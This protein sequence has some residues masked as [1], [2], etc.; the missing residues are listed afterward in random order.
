MPG[1]E[2]SWGEVA[3]LLELLHPCWPE[4]LGMGVPREGWA[5]GSS[6]SDR[7]SRADLGHLAGSF[8]TNL[9]YWSWSWSHW[10]G[11]W[12]VVEVE[13]IGCSSWG[14]WES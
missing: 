1:L 9:N 11:R 4:G 14:C 12:R 8:S 2:I 7:S 13:W 10:R 3:L 6:S 5:G